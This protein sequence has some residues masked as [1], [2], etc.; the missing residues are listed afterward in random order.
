MADL[1]SD[2]LAREQNALAD[3]ENNDDT[4]EEEAPQGINAILYK[5]FKN[6]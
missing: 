4:N 5:N 1:V 2:F 6:T 3:L